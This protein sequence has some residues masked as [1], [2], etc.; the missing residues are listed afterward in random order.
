MQKFLIISFVLTVLFIFPDSSFS[1]RIVTTKWGG[2]A[3]IAYEKGFMY[4]LRKHSDGGV[5]LF[6]QELIENDSPGAGPSEKEQHYQK[7]KN[8]FVFFQNTPPLCN[9]K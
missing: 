1:E 5:C 8:K 7:I 6:N 2:K 4:N 3:E 9:K